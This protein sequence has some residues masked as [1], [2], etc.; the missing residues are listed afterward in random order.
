MLE[1]Y[2]QQELVRCRPWTEAVRR[3]RFNS[4]TEKLLE[5]SNNT[6]RRRE[7]LYMIKK[8]DMVE[9]AGTDGKLG[10]GS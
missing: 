6:P 8:G 10:D 2:S 4:V 9:M 5:K 3:D 1:G 7:K